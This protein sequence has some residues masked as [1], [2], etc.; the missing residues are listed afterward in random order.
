MMSFDLE[1]L[2]RMSHEYEGLPINKKGKLMKFLTSL[3]ILYG[4]IALF[5][6][7]G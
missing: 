4:A 2:T 1:L 5:L 3:C 6:L 7:A